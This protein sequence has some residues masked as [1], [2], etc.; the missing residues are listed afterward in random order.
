MVYCDGNSFSGDR[1]EPLIVRGLDG[2]DKPLYFRGRRIVDAAI[3]T[4]LGMGL[5]KAST[6]LLTGCSAGGLATFLHADY[7]H[8]RLKATVPT[9]QKYRV[10]P[11]S[12]FFLFHNNVED[13]PVYPVQMKRIFTMANS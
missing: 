7:V 6:V 4:L 10:A 8:D 3:E 5:N 12:G 11:M 1:D 2:K 13:K 9:L